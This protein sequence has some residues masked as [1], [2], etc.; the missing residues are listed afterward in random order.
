MTVSASVRARRR[1]RRR[2][3]V[4]LAVG[5]AVLVSGCAASGS[6][7]AGPVVVITSADTSGYHGALLDTPFV[8]PAATFT[9]S[10]G[11]RLDPSS[12]RPGTVTLVYFGYTHCPDECPAMLAD[13]ASA[14]RR[15]DP[16]VRDQVRLLFVTTDPPRDTPEVL[17]DYLARFDPSFVGLTAD[18]G[19]IRAAARQLGIGL[20]G[21][22]SLPGGGYDVGHG[23]QLI[24]FGPDGKGRLVW[25]AGVPVGDLRDDLARLVA[26]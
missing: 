21:T 13:V 12:A 18:M 10:D 8:M 6:A 7:D 23:T 22:T 20:T 1:L 5:A 16:A 14:L 19:T 17:H 26:S 9:T 4:V 11:G 15:S 25:S 2:A 24:G 3:P